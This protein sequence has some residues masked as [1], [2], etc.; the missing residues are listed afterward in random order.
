M[1]V[2]IY[3]TNWKGET[4]ERIIE[5]LNLYFGHNE[6]HPKG[7]WLL[8]A[9]DCIKGEKRSFAMKDIHY[10]EQIEKK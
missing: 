4:A 5:P 6:W 3:Y 10:W 1:K 2:K 8:E 9:T 7:Q